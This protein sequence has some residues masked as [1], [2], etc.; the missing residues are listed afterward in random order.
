MAQKVAVLLED[1][2]T[3]GPADGT[4]RFGID[5]ANYEIDLNTGNAS[6]LHAI[7]RPYVENGRKT[8]AAKQRH[9]RMTPNRQRS[10]DIRAWAK[11]TGIQ[12]SERGRIPADIVAQYEATH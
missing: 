7:L 6:E 1:D 9:T 3:G 5:G 8:S 4:V 2:L 11:N 12:V 10:A